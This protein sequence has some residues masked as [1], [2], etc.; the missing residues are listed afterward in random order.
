MK[1][2]NQNRASAAVRMMSSRILV[3]GLQLLFIPV[4]VRILGEVGYGFA[5]WVMSVRS[6]VQLIDLD[7]PQGLRHAM[8]STANTH[9]EAFWCNFRTGLSLNTV[10]GFI[11]ATILGF[12]WSL[13]RSEQYSAFNSVIPIM[14]ALA[15]LQ[16][17]IDCVGSTLS[18]PFYATEDFRQITRVGTFVPVTALVIN[19]VL[20]Y[21][22]RS[23]VAMMI[24]GVLESSMTLLVNAYCFKQSFGM[25]RLRWG[26]DMAAARSIL[27]IAM[28]S[29]P[30]NIS[31]RVAGVADRVILGSAAEMSLVT[32][33]NF[34]TKIPLSIMQIVGS[35]TT[36]IVPEMVHVAQNEPEKFVG[37]LRRNVAF[38]S[39]LYSCTIIISSGFAAVILKAWVGLD[40]PGF[41]TL[42]I[43][44]AI[45]YTFE[46][47]FSTI[48]TAFF[49][50]KKAHL[51]FPFALWNA[52]VTVFATGPISKKFGLVGL[53]WMNAA[54]DVLQL[55][56]LH[57]L[58]THSIVKG[59]PMWWYI[60][61]LGTAVLVC[62]CLAF[63]IAWALR[64]VPVGREAFAYLIL[65][66]VA[67]FGCFTYA[68][69]LAWVELPNSVREK[70]R[71][72]KFAEKLFGSEALKLV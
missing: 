7:V 61:R 15:A 42:T 67:S 5:I 13:V 54:I 30:G 12:A 26:F 11:G 27:S 58:L 21:A 44:M 64:T 25:K 34:A 50:F 59:E 63:A 18:H 28:K 9:E 2:P 10:V 16:M 23:P 47:N 52:L 51:L 68:T 43:L 22:L 36:M 38:M 32:Y 72:W 53:G 6:L 45:Y 70:L 14:F 40:F 31:G 65:I 3:I 19:F 69:R 55:V 1:T 20:V 41:A 66:P 49:A 60:R 46:M 48:S 62:A 24:A 17:I 33:Y 71:K 8:I 56:P 37:I 4:S 29:Y 57:W 39:V 35:S